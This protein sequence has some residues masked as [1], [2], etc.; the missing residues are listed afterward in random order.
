MATLISGGS[1][2][3]TITDTIDGGGPADE[4]VDTLDGNGPTGSDFPTTPPVIVREDTRRIWLE[5]MDGSVV[6]PLNVDVDRILKA[7]ATGLQLPPLDVVTIKTPGMP[8]SSLQEVN[9]D[10]R[11]V[12]LPL[13]FASDTSH[14]EFMGKLT[15]LRG[16]IAP[17]WDL[18]NVGDTGTFRLGVSSLNGERLLDVV[19]K[20]GWTGGRVSMVGLLAGRGSRT[21]G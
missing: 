13:K 14:A 21:S 4:F 20:D 2:S 6:V 1:P 3:L 18:V 5:S 15:E 9:V 12:F 19:Y 17:M 16:L 11:E 8:G 10:E 7:G